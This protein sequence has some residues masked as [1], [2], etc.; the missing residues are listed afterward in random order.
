[1]IDEMTEIS[2]EKLQLVMG[3]M[4]E[5]LKLSEEKQKMI[6]L[7]YGL[8]GKGTVTLK[9]MVKVLNIKPKQLKKEI[10]EVDRLVFN[11]LKNRV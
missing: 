2:A 5:S 7:R 11:Y 6:R 4:V 10:E 3:Q 1:M 9:E 8:D